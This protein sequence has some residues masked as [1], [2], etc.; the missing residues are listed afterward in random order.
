MFKS[1]TKNRPGVQGGSELLFRVSEGHGAAGGK[2]LGRLFLSELNS[3]SADAWAQ[4]APGRKK[5]W[6]RAPK[7]LFWK[8]KFS[9]AENRMQ[10]FMLDVLE[11]AKTNPEIL[12]GTES[13]DDCR[14]C[15]SMVY[16]GDERVHLKLLEVGVLN[17]GLAAASKDALEL[18]RVIAKDGSDKARYELVNTLRSLEGAL[19][20]KDGLSILD[21]SAM[22]G[23]LQVKSAVL[24]VLDANEW[25]RKHGGPKSILSIYDS[26]SDKSVDHIIDGIVRLLEEDSGL[27]KENKNDAVMCVM[28]YLAGVSKKYNFRS[29]DSSFG[30]SARSVA[31]NMA[32][33]GGEDV[34]LSMIEFASHDTEFARDSRFLSAIARYDR[35]QALDE[36]L[37]RPALLD[38][39]DWGGE[40]PASILLN[41]KKSAVL[42]L[43]KSARK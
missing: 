40:T 5:P 41:E 2:E 25:V 28:E 37:S 8:H 9:A 13:S 7:E 29:S 22:Y 34:R 42:A 4:E 24:N 36:L 16:R 39:N 6:K 38:L 18:G 27:R 35:G 32:R 21:L 19:R 31:F 26:I 43:T 10:D 11:V 12:M 17:N 30:F 3:L 15:N 14:L 33:F 1:R 23:D 20:T